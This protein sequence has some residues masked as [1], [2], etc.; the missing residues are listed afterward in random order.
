VYFAL[1][2]HGKPGNEKRGNE[3]ALLEE[4]V[5]PVYVRG[6]DNRRNLGRLFVREESCDVR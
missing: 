2:P 6:S 5:R 4:K 1:I 3:L